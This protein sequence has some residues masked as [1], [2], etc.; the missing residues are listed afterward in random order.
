MTPTR[1]QSSGLGV[2]S[3]RHDVPFLCHFGTVRALGWRGEWSKSASQR[4]FT[5]ALSS[6]GER[7]SIPAGACAVRRLKNGAIPRGLI[8]QQMLTSGLSY[9]DWARR[10]AVRGR[11]QAVEP[12]QRRCG[13]RWRRRS[14]LARPDSAFIDVVAQR[15]RRPGTPSGRSR[16]S[17]GSR[18][19]AAEAVGH[20]S[21]R[22][23]GD[24]YKR[25]T[26]S[27]RVD[28][29]AKIA[30]GHLPGGEITAAGAFRRLRNGRTSRRSN[31]TGM[32]R[33]IAGEPRPS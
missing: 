27:M 9:G 3:P 33:T 8:E 13:G 28:A 1:R 14:C 29:S 30:G 22:T 12:N 21:A 4:S 5:R 18:K 17:K 2:R 6:A 25:V 23:A 26:L 7:C 24:I 19:V 32:S 10:A 11:A 31:L 16:S 15:S 20:A